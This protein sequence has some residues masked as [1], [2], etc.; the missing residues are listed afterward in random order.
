MKITRIWHGRIK[1][2]DLPEYRA[3]IE[4][5]GIKEYRDISGNLSA[6]ILTRIEDDICHFMTVT[7][8]DSYESIKA[9]AGEDYRLAKYYDQDKH[10]LLEFET[11][12]THYETHEY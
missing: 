7:E 3:Y 8:W 1:K 5:T 12:V 10:F 9:F 4:A 6:K 11:Y 2:E